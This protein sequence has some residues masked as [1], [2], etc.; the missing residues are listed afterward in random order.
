M[1]T[2]NDSVVATQNIE[3]EEELFSIPR[4][5]LLNV[6]N[7]DF[8]SEHPRLLERM[9]GNPWLE[10]I[11]TMLYEDAQPNSKWRPYFDVLPAEGQFDTLMYWN[12]NELEELEASAVRHKIGRESAD[13]MFWER[14]VPTVRSE[15]QVFGL[16]PGIDEPDVVRTAHRMGSLIMAYGFDIESERE[17]EIDEE[18]YVSD[19]EDEDMPKAMVP[20]ADMLNADAERNN[21]RLFY[22]PDALVMK[23]IKSIAKGEEVFNWYGPLPRSDLLRRYGY[24]TDNHAQ[25]DVVELPSQLILDTAAGM[26][27]MRD[28]NFEE[29]VAERV[30]TSFTLV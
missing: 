18:G 29:M 11:L 21:A 6:K 22:E 4:T 20:M 30:R 10:L 17:R 3:E 9:D 23:A 13:R 19:E 27:W 5:I 2:Y 26:S 24:V 16:G 15:P 12:A 1:T 14:I 8:S 25:W 7:S 28:A